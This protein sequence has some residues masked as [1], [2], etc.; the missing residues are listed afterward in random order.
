ML[1]A[2]G[3]MACE[4]S[5]VVIVF[6]MEQGFIERTVISY[7]LLFIQRVLMP[8]IINTDVMADKAYLI[9]TIKVYGRHRQIDI[10]KMQAIFI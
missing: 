4:F 7:H 5:P 8:I 9:S 3:L 10:R 1:L 6:F 2:I